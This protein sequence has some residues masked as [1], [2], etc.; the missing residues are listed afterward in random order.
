MN[1][2]QVGPT[3]GCIIAEQ[4]VALKKGN[5]IKIVTSKP[6]SKPQFF[7]KFVCKCTVFDPL[8]SPGFAK[9]GTAHSGRYE[10]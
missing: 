9:W 8:S 1:G 4:F 3:A 6:K 10:F 7:R 2:A 5:T